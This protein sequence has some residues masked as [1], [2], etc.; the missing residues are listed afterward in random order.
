MIALGSSLFAELFANRGCIA[1]NPTMAE[2]VRHMANEICQDGTGTDGE[3]AN[4]IR[5]ASPVKLHSKQNI[6]CF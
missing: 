2:L 3:G 6:C 1:R 4:S 5:F